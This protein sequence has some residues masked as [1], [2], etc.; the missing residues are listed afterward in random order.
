M[1]PM[2][3]VVAAMDRWTEWN[4][5]G[6]KL[7]IGKRVL[8]VDVARMGVDKTVMAERYALVIRAIHVFSKLPLTSVAGYAKVIG[9]NMH[10]NIETDGGY[11]ASVYDMLHEDGVPMLHPITVGGS[12]NMRDRTGELGFRDVRSAMWWNMRELLDPNNGMDVKLPPV[13]QLKADL[14][15]PKYEML[16][17]G[18]IAIEKKDYTKMR[19]GRSTDYGDAV[20]LAFWEATGG[21]GVVF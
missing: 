9:A 1:I 14:V 7:D 16:R 3:W 12:T 11:G 18:I 4:A 21:G 15:A 19:L 17:N 6:S 20:C 2:S 10:I 8:G 13:E 5:S